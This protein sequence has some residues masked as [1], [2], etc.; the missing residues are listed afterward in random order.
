MDKNI[1]NT[2][3]EYAEGALSG[4]AL[5]EFEQRL[6][7]D[8]ALQTELDLYLALK[9]M[10]NQRLKKQLSEMARIEALSPQE[11]PQLRALRV[12]HWLAIAAS[13]AVLL[14]A[15]WWYFKPKKVDA[16]Q[17]AQTYIAKPYPSPVV[18]MGEDTLSVALQR[19]FLAYRTEDFAAAAQQ[20]AVLAAGSESRD[21]VLFYTGEA[22][23]QTGQW[24]LAVTYFDRVRPGYW[25]ESADWRCALALLKSGQTPAAKSLLE[26]LRQGT[27]QS[28]AEKL[29]NA[30]E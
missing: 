18:S 9:A 25:R 1:D 13:L 6:K 12:Q 5:H 24:E 23:L 22:M 19:A 17:L 4:N 28:E 20:L 30:L 29:L 21:E 14:I 2:L 26:N 8:P 11:P 10:D 3:R 7:E 16:V 27:R 15:G